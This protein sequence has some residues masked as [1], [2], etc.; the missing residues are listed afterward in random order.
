MA[1][2]VPSGIIKTELKGRAVGERPENLVA[3]GWTKDEA[4]GFTGHISP[5]WHR[6]VEGVLSIGFFAEARHCNEHL[7]TVHGGAILTFADV[8][9]GFTAFR[10]LGHSRCATVNLQAYFLAPPKRGQFISCTPEITRQTR[11]LLFIRALIHS[12]G[13]T[14]ASTEGLWKVLAVR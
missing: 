14:V 5:F 13:R 2:V 4:G 7:G 8:A 6:V 9:G 11:D 3:D 10:A 1:Y 12:D